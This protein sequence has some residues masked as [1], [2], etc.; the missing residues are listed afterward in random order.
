MEL[1]TFCNLCRKL[2]DFNFSQ[3]LRNASDYNCVAAR[4]WHTRHFHSRAGNATKFDALRCLRK[5]E[6]TRVP[7]L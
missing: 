5:K 7:W 4:V 2:N 6:V 3:R 1:N